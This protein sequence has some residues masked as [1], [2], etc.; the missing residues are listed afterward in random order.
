MPDANDNLSCATALQRILAAA[1][2]ASEKHSSQKRKG[3]AG[4]PYINHLIEV[5]ELIAGSSS[6]LDANL[7]MAYLY[8]DAFNGSIILAEPHQ[9][10]SQQ[11][12]M[13]Q[14]A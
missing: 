3:A 12:L 6:S 9:F 14:R 8:K 7:V 11:L 5:A 4:E 1:H 13:P 10:F 2:F